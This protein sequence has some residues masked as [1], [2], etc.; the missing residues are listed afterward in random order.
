LSPGTVKVCILSMSSRPVCR[1][2]LLLALASA[3]IHVSEP[4]GTRD[5]ILLSQTRDSP[6]LEGYVPVVISPRN[7]VNQ[8]YPQ[9]LDIFSSPRTTPRVTVELFG[10]NFIQDSSKTPIENIYS[11]SCVLFFRSDVGAARTVQKTP[12]SIVLPLLRV[13]L[14]FVRYV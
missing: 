2:Q 11:C 10:P 12:L 7:W 9:A 3:V 6:N 1:L 8:L 5:H 13:T 14:F 4:R